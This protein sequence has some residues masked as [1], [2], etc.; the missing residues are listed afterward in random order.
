MIDKFSARSIYIL[1]DINQIKISYFGIL[2]VVAPS[3]CLFKNK[4]IDFPM[5]GYYLFSYDLYPFIFS[6]NG[7]HI[8]PNPLSSDQVGNGK[9]TP[10]A[11]LSITYHFIFQH[12]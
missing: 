4:T 2:K 8:L 3:C 1:R 9:L 6:L 11:S 10:C 5:V 12:Y 7:F